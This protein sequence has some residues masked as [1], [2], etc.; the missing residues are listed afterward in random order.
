[1]TNPL[2]LPL[3][4]KNFFK[5]LKNTN[6]IEGGGLESMGISPLAKL[7]N[8]FLFAPVKIQWRVLNKVRIKSV[9]LNDFEGGDPQNN[10]YTICATNHSKRN[11]V[12]AA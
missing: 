6:A 3:S 4:Q 10:I 1:M 7:L 12:E 8:H 9:V 2:F 5:S 11:R